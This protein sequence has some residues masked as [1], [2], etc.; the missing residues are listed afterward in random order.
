MEAKKLTPEQAEELI[1]EAQ[2]RWGDC[3]SFYSDMYDD[4]QDDW[5]FTHGEGHWD[6]TTKKDRDREGRPCLVLNQ[7]L[8]YVHQVINDIKQTRLSIRVTPVDSGADIETAKIR[9]GIIR[10]IERQSKSK[11]IYGAAAMNA[12]GAGIG[13]IEL[14]V[15]Y[16]SPETFDQ[17]IKIHRVLDFTSCFLDPQSEELDGSDA[18]YGFK[19][20]TYSKK[21]FEELYPDASPVSFCGKRVNGSNEEEVNIVSYYYKEADTKTLYEVEIEGKLI[22]LY[23]DDLTKLDEEDIPYEKMRS[24]EVELYTQYHCVL[25][26][27][28][29]LTHEEF[30]CQYIPLVPIIGEE[31]F[32]E[33]K[34]KFRSLINPAKDAQRM[35][36]YWS[37]TSTEIIALQPKA[38][39]TAPVGSFVSEPDK[40]E[41]AN[42]LNHATL[43]WDPVLDDNGTLLPPPQRTAP[44]MGSPT[45]M[46][47]A[48]VAR[49]DIRLALG[50]PQSN[51]GENSNAISGV[52]IRAQQIEGDNATFHFI[53]NL[54]S[55]IGQVGRIINELIPHIYSSSTIAKIIGTDEEEQ[56][57]PINTPFVKQ[58][59]EYMAANSSQSADGIYDMS[60]GKYDIAVDVGASY[61]SERQ[62]MADK[63]IEVA[64]IRPDIMEIAGDLFF[65]ALDIPMSKEIAERVKSQMPPEVLGDDPQAAQLQKAS[66]QMQ[67]MQEQ[68]MNY[69]A[70]LADKE[71]DKQF[72]QATEAAKIE[73]EKEKLAIEIEKANAEIAKTYSEIQKNDAETVGQ[74]EQNIQA[75]TEIS[76]KVNDIGQAVEHILSDIETDIDVVEVTGSPQEE[77]EQSNRD[78]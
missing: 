18:S 63:L 44:I 41:T 43:E 37:T 60:V 53:D 5:K 4:A 21:R 36:N 42:R 27:E 17:E 23:G 33:D 68:L 3:D 66:Q 55:S 48:E 13:W 51:M 12:V 64:A 67:Q 7:C 29:V 46:Q 9:S 76:A 39:W 26:G 1:Q 50:M 71:K 19:I 52:A 65:S 40:W 77:P 34:R 15:D 6:A 35:Y 57:I 38:P 74:R 78:E 69:E 75:M 62:E 10:N 58:G 28:D 59:G 70:A 22:S 45:M 8:P 73:L 16:V 30:P 32:S 72:E 2:D 49:G 25:S 31:Y 61:S 47:Q 11:D 14:D 24:R 54:T 56:D 20:V